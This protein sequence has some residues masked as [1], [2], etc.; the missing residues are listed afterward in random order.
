VTKGQCPDGSPPPC[1]RRVGIDTNAFIVVPFAVRGDA[2]AQYL[3][4]SM[5]DLLHMA[6]DG[7][8]KIR[9]EIAPTTLRRLTQLSDPRDARTA[10]VVALEIGAGR[11]IAG[12]VVAL[13][14]EV[15][16][17]AE[18]FDAT[19]GR[20]QFAVERRATLDN[21]AVVVDSLA[22][23]ILARRNVSPGERAR[24][25]TG[26]YATK[27]PKALQAFLV[28]KQL[29]R[30]GERR[31][32]ADSVLS[33]LRQDP[34]FG[35]AHVLLLQLEGS[36]ANVTGVPGGQ[37]AIL[38]AARARQERFP[39]RVRLLLYD[40]QGNRARLLAFVQS[41]ATRFPADPDVAFWLADTYFHHGLNLGESRE[42]VFAAFRDALAFD[43]QD[44]E[45]LGH[46][47]VLL[48][49]AGDSA[50]SRR[51]YERCRVTAPRSICGDELGFRA[52][53]RREDPRSIAV[54]SDS[55]YWGGLMNALLR[56]T[57]WN[58]A[59]G[60][61][62]TDSF[63]QIQTSRSR[64]RERRAAAYIVRSNVALARGQYETAWAFL[65][66]SA[67]FGIP[68]T[69]GYQILHDIVTGTKKA[70]AGAVVERRDDPVEFTTRAWWAA[71]RLPADSAE[72]FLSAL[73]TSPPPD[74]VLRFEI[75][76]F[77]PGLRG[78]AALGRGDTARALDLLTRMRN[79]AIRSSNP[80]R[81]LLP[82]AAFA[83]ALAQIEAASGS[84]AKAKLYLADIYPQNHYVP[85]IGDAEELRAK[86]ALA[87]ADTAAARMHLRNVIAVWENA[88]PPMQPR[89]AAA[90]A[91]LS[92]LERR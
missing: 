87:L 18:V 11:V 70:E 31:L 84:A 6:L 25:N 66:S 51:A 10:S 73:E 35:L 74:E 17:R 29:A 67:S 71:V 24:L 85:F 33:A 20:T 32:A 12:T 62:I 78:L 37:R 23:A 75:K 3:G 47:G 1:A 61:A 38:Q 39:E 13:G 69:A 76:E 82:E 91:T 42:R 52:V 45:L 2:S 56:I 9:I 19:R 49:E 81:I 64:T 63:A 89:V 43:D 54:G 22:A 72:P 60:L 57:P 40:P 5:V 53:F 34:D 27:S 46:Y 88:D 86:V 77:A 92:R 83:L 59:F 41:A 36:Q 21:V 26:E 68:A 48:D 7:V 16:V 58:P 4:A 55:L 80:R 50:G 8:A 79:R 44:P 90:R 28:A 15:R 30:R 14:S 65:D